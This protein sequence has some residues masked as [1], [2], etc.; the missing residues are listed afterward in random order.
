VITEAAESYLAGQTLQAL[1]DRFNAAGRLP[2]SGANWSPKTL[3]QVLRNPMVIG[4]RTDASGITT[5]K[6]AGILDWATWQKVTAR[7]DE[8][9]TRKGISQASVPALLTS[10]IYCAACFKPMYR[11]HAGNGNTHTYY[12]CRRGCKSMCRVDQADALAELYLLQRYGSNER[13]VTTV[14]PGHGHDDEISGVKADIRDLDPEQDDYDVRLSVL[15]AELARLKALPATAP[16]VITKSTGQTVG[17]FWA[18]QDASGKRD[19]LRGMVQVYYRQGW[20]APRVTS[21]DLTPPEAVKALTV[22]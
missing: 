5:L 11:I 6:T 10:L 4:R 15:R 13:T 9:A 8:R 1:C 22:G 14:I 17:Q 12:Y 7:M 18:E 20:D 3:S 2:R 16:K 19:M 21:G